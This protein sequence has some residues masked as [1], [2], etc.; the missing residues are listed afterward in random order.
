[1]E[2]ARA[3]TPPKPPDDIEQSRYFPHIGWVAMH[4][5]L[6]K[7]DEDVFLLWKCS[8]YGA[9]SHSHAGQNAFVLSA[10]GKPL[11]IASGYYDYYGSPHH[12]GWT[13]QTKANNGILVDG[14]GQAE[15]EGAG[16][17][18]RYLSDSCGGWGG[19]FT[20]ARGDA[21]GVY[22]GKLTKAL[23]HV[24]KLDAR[25]FVIA[26]DLQAPAPATFSWLLH[27][28]EKMALDEKRGEIVCS[29]GDARLSARILAPQDVTIEQS[30]RFDPPP[31]RD[32]AIATRGKPN[33]PDQY[34]ASATTRQ[35]SK[36]GAF[37]ARLLAGKGAGPKVGGERVEDSADAVC[38]AWDDEAG[39][40]IVMMRRRGAQGEVRFEEARLSGEFAALRLE[41]G[42]VA[43]FLVSEAQALSWSKEEVF[44]SPSPASACISRDASGTWRI[45]LGAG[46]AGAPLSFRAPAGAP[47]AGRFLPERLG[48]PRKAEVRLSDGK[49]VVSHPGDGGTILL[50]GR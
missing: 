30:D 19:G 38:A 49:L 23:R 6:A 50:G 13:R 3:T 11:A 24:A 17:V 7:P 9:K 1:V 34:H 14:A 37:L 36:S 18:E 16:K 35:K 12:Y 25:T 22:Q 10:F 32:Q 42:K 48:E 5:A 33:R 41:G 21:A 2:K 27:A 26:D 15:R 20:Y 45:G 31:L 43:R 47:A 46:Q 40:W 39:R 8:P 29:L 4:S 28:F 44:A